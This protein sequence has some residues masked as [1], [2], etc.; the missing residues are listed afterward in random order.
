MEGNPRLIERIA[1]RIGGE[2][3]IDMVIH[4]TILE[5]RI[6]TEKVAIREAPFRDVVEVPLPPFA[7]VSEPYQSVWN[8][9]AEAARSSLR[10]SSSGYLVSWDF[11]YPEIVRFYRTVLAEDAER[12]PLTDNDLTFLKGTRQWETSANSQQQDVP[13]LNQGWVSERSCGTFFGWFQGQTTRTPHK[14]EITP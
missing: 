2:P 6:E 4:K 1:Q 9:L 14:H 7:P 13:A 10:N 8:R 11:V 12:R 5:E 3:P